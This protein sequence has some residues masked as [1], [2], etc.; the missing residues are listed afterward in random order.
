MIKNY[1]IVWIFLCAG[2]WKGASAQNI[3]YAHSDQIYSSIKNI[4]RIYVD[5]GRGKKNKNYIDPL[6]IIT[7]Q[8]FKLEPLKVPAYDLTFTNEKY[9]LPSYLGIDGAYKIDCV[10]VKSHNYFNIWENNKLNPYG[11]NGEHFSDSIKLTLY[12]FTDSIFWHA[13]LDISIITSDFGLRRASW[14]YGIDL[15]VKVGTPV[16]AAFDGITRIIGYER[17]GFGRFVV[18]RHANGFESLYAHLSRT[19]I[20]LGEEVKAGDIIG[21]GGNSGRSTAPHLH[22]EIRYAGNAID[23]NMIFDFESNQIRDQYFFVKPQV[24]TYLEEANK[25]RYHVIRRGDTL[26]GIGYRYGV[27]INKL[28]YLNNLRRTSI[29]SIGRR[30]RIN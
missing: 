21:T 1:L 11:I 5:P 12:N 3:S 18:I 17:R 13:P 20:R 2:G 28:Y 15:R 16:Y 25:I 6:D 14:H 24:F 26:S 19:N 27:S 8:N 29:L 10:W 7:K 9:A 23:P 22:F 4:S 30:I